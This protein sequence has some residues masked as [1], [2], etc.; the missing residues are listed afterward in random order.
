[1]SVNDPLT[2]LSE[3][4]EAMDW[5]KRASAW[6]A[7]PLNPRR[8][9][10]FPRQVSILE[11]P[12]ALPQPYI[13]PRPDAA[14]GLVQAHKLKSQFLNNERT[15]WVYTPPGYNLKRPPRG[16]LVLFDGGSFTSQVPTPTILDNLLAEGRIP[17]LAAVFVGHPDLSTRNR[18]LTCSEPFTRFLVE[19]MLP[20]LRRTYGLNPDPAQTVVAGASNGGLA[21]V[22]AAFRQPK[23]FGLAL[24]MSGA[25][26]YSP[27]P[28]KEPEWLAR[29]FAASARL[30]VRF[31][32]DVGLMED[33]ASN[34]AV[35]SMLMA[36]RHL[37]DVLLSKGYG[38]HYLEF[39]GG[40]E[41]VNWRGTLADGLI[42]LFGEQPGR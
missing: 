3:P 35:P 40:H 1:L 16:L 33:Q 9:Q 13:E 31:H 41:F 23:V 8:F 25:F 37:R 39:N 12:G 14:R 24:S 18:E 7:D 19:E 20:W 38:V 34:A 21:A 29:Q 17:P 27:P 26:M 11:L 30:P 36:N 15:V 22:Y 42:A 5:A 10:A 4:K 28:E 6:L 32:L 2:P